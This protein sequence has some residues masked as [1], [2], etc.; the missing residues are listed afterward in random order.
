METE[1]IKAYKGFNNDMT[2]RDFQYEVG[3]EYEQ[4]GKIE[5]CENGFHACENPMDVFGYYPP[6]R[7]RYCEVEQ[8]GTI[9]RSQYKIASSKIRIQCEIGLSDIIQAG[10]KFILDKVYWKDDNATNTGDCSAAT[11]TG[12]YSA[13]TNTG[14]CSAATN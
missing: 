7:S 13:A 14:D 5:V 9:G 6:S 8:S 2:C 10:V 1:K 12:D 3:K 11:N 4:K